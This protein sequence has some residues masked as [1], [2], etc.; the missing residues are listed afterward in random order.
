LEKKYSAI[1][2]QENQGKSNNHM[3]DTMSSLYMNKNK[4]TNMANNDGE[5]IDI[6]SDDDDDEAATQTPAPV[7]KE[8]GISNKEGRGC[9]HTPWIRMI[10]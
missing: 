1:F 3:N 10:F 2:V 4:S 8:N 6:S 9:L 5:L 7:N